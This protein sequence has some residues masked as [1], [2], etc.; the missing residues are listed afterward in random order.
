MQEWEDESKLRAFSTFGTY[1][2]FVLQTKKAQSP[3][4]HPTNHPNNQHTKTSP[5]AINQNI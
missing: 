3:A 1:R 5:T 2:I 4:P